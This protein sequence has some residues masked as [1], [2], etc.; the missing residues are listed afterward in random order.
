LF[1]VRVPVRPVPIASVIR[2]ILDFAGRDAEGNGF[3]GFGRNLNRRSVIVYRLFVV[4]TYNEVLV[5]LI[6]WLPLLLPCTHESPPWDNPRFDLRQMHLYHHA[7][8]AS[9]AVPDL[10]N[11]I[12]GSTNFEENL[13]LDILLLRSDLKLTVLHVPRRTAS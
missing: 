4:K 3:I 2:L 9:V 10:C 1:G 5:G 6:R 12:T 8:L 11:T 7:L 13:T